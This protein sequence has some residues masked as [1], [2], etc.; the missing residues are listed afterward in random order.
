MMMMMMAWIVWLVLEVVESTPQGAA[1]YAC[2][3]MDPSHGG[4][5]QTGPCPYRFLLDKTEIFANQCVVFTI[6]TYYPRKF[7]GF[8]V[9]ARNDSDIPVGY[10][11]IYSYKINLINCPGGER[12][13]AT[14]NQADYK[15]VIDMRWFPPH[16]PTGPFSGNITFYA[17]VLQ[18]RETFWV[19][20]KVS[21][22]LRVI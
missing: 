16:P 1:T 17:T 3:T 4:Q 14:H 7:K 11:D 6:K 15:E 19:K 10:F 8:M 5:P 12:N 18:D 2:E 20:Q 22:I 13:T 21:P 9:Q